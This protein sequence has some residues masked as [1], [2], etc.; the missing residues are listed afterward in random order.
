MDTWNLENHGMHSLPESYTTD[1]NIASP[2]SGTIFQPS[3]VPECLPRVSSDS[4]TSQ[5]GLLNVRRVLP[6]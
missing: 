4:K 5:S 6:K 3:N 2:D 1:A